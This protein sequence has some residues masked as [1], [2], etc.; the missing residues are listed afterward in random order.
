MERWDWMSIFVRN[1]GVCL[2]A[3]SYSEPDSLHLTQCNLVL[4]PVI[5]LRCSLR[6]MAGHLLGVLQPSVVLGV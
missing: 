6:L 5:E 2:V 1:L 3:S 4:C